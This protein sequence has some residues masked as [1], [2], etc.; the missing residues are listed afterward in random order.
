VF[1][2]FEPEFLILMLQESKRELESVF[3]SGLEPLTTENEVKGILSHLSALP[4]P[5]LSPPSIPPSSYHH[6][7]LNLLS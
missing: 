3:I 4:A 1:N 7:Y 5:T 6:Q 2:D